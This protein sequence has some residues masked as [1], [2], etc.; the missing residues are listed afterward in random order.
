MAVPWARGPP[1]DGLVPTYVAWPVSEF[2][3]LRADVEGN[4]QKTLDDAG[5]LGDRVRG[6]IRAERIR[7]SNDLPNRFRIPYGQG[8]ALV[9]DAGLVLDPITGQGIGDAFRDAELLADAIA[10]GLAGG[11]PGRALAGYRR[12]RDRAALPMYRFTRQ[13]ARLA[14]MRPAERELFA[15]LASDPQETQRF[16]GVLTGVHAP[17]AVFSPT[18]LIRLLGLR[19]FLRLARR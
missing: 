3:E 4:L 19:G 1:N 14:P 18:H 6:G 12:Q 17:T 11:R 5:D 8:W 10:A 16:F 2:D 7:C 9:G 13:L 15:A